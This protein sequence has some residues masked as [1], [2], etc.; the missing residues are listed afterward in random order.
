MF[1]VLGAMCRQKRS[2]EIN[3]V[4]GH[5]DVWLLVAEAQA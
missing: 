3:F 1:L 5:A 2:V 4:G